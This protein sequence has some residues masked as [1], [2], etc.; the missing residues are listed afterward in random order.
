[1]GLIIGP[2]RKQNHDTMPKMSAESRRHVP[3][4]LEQNFGH[5]SDTFAYLVTACVWQLCPTH[6]CHNDNTNGS[7]IVIQIGGV[8]VCACTPLA[9]QNNQE[10]GMP[11]YRAG[12]QM[13]SP[14]NLCL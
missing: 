9:L 5:F 12:L 10:E 3:N 6:A 14:T 4:P 11:L 1:M 13:N 7:D 8:C 2:P